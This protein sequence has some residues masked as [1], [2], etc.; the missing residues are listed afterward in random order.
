MATFSFHFRF[1]LLQALQ[2]FVFL[3]GGLVDDL[4][5]V[6]VSRRTTYV[7]IGRKYDDGLLLS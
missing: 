6:I 2:A 3:V 7:S 5:L 1:P 4:F